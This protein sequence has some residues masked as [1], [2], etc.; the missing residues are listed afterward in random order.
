L[1]VP[2]PPREIRTVT[3]LATR[4][5][6]VGPTNVSGGPLGSARVLFDPAT[7][8]LSTFYPTVVFGPPPPPP[9]QFV[10]AARLVSPAAA[11][12]AIRTEVSSLG[13]PR[14]CPGLSTC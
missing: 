14:S 4:G 6:M 9:G 5:V 3:V 2:D 11:T 10:G 7:G 8:A 13:R 12:G 1:A